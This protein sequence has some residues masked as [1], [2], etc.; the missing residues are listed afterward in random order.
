MSVLVSLPCHPASGRRW[1]APSFMPAGIQ[2]CSWAYRRVTHRILR[3]VPSDDSRI[4]ISL[5][6]SGA[7]TFAER[8]TP[9]RRAPAG[10]RHVHEP[11]TVVSSYYDHGVSKIDPT[12]PVPLP[13]G[14]GDHPQPDS[15]GRVALWQP[16]HRSGDH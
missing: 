5:I 9:G 12:G 14:C 16:D 7:T 1:P 13:P 2:L 8:N 4:V 10:G 3:S 6:N 15:L 11:G